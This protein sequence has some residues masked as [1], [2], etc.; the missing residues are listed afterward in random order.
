MKIVSSGLKNLRMVRWLD[1]FFKKNLV[2]SVF[3]PQNM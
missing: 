3:G 1:I 2:G